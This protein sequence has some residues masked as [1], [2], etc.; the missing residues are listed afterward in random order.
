MSEFHKSVE[1]FFTK[2]NWRITLSVRS[3]LD[4]LSDSETLLGVSDIQI[5]LREKKQKFD[6]STIYRILN[7]LKKINLI[8]EFENKWKR[9]TH[10][11]N[12]TDEHHFLICDKCNNVEEIFL[13]YKDSI[14][15]QLLEEKKFK[16]EHVRLGF[17]GICNNCS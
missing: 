4:I 6:T 1:N 5:I 2:N 11:H 17:F 13:D 8:H 15:D 16:L 3:V 14:A 9:C 10:S 12:T 7:K